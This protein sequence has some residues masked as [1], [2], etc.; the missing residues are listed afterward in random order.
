MLDGVVAGNAGFPS[1]AYFMPLSLFAAVE[2]AHAR[3][4]QDVADQLRMA[5]E[6]AGLA[7]SVSLDHERAVLEFDE[8]HSGAAP[9]VIAVFS[10]EAG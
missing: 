9:R 3:F 5:A 1:M 6:K 8:A 2:R 10:D 7:A 4:R